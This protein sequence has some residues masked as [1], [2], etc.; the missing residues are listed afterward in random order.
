MYFKINYYI[1]KINAKNNYKNIIYSRNSFNCYGQVQQTNNTLPGKNSKHIG[2]IA[3]E[4][5]TEAIC[6]TKGLLH[7]FA[8]ANPSVRNDGKIV[9]PSAKAEEANCKNV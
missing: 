2:V 1:C 3:R 4:G 9:A 5:L 7:S 8:K 6:R